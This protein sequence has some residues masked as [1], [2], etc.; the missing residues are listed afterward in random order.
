MLRV[1]P[2]KFKPVLQCITLL[3]VAWT[4][5]KGVTLYTGI[6][7]LNAKQLSLE[8]IK[9]TTCTYFVAKSRTSLYFVQQLFAT[10]NLF[11]NNFAKQ[12]ARFCC[13]FYRTF[14]PFQDPAL[15]S[16]TC[17]SHVHLLYFSRA[18]NWA[19]VSRRIL[20]TG[21]RSLFFFFTAPKTLAAEGCLFLMFPAPCAAKNDAG[22]NEAC[23]F[24]FPADIRTLTD[25]LLLEV[26]DKSK[27]G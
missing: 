18:W 14:K 25:L 23:M 4:I 5:N 8:S 1:L 9:R 3:Q 10:F 20:S 2:P 13:P 16:V 11:C 7:L 22:L 15:T 19:H 27:A 24:F 26:T 17:F 12:V 21:W 6:A